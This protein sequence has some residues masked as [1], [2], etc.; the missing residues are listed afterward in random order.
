MISTTVQGIAETRAALEQAVPAA[1]DAVAAAV[2]QSAEQLHADVGEIM[3]AMGIYDTGRMFNAR[4]IRYGEASHAAAVGWFAS[5]FPGPTFYPPYV[6]FGT[7]KVPARDPLTP[8]LARRAPD[9]RRLCQAAG[10]TA[11]LSG[12]RRPW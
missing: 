3:R 4:M 1:E 12:L 8:A 6:V 9:F 7:R 2:V 5:D 10:A 11:V